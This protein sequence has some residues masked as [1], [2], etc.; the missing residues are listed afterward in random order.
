MTTT[1]PPDGKEIAFVRKD[2]TGGATS[3]PT[4][5]CSSLPLTVGPAAEVLRESRLLKRAGGNSP[6]GRLI[7]FRA[8]MRAGFEADRW[9]LLVFD[10]AT[11]AVRN[12]TEPFD[13]QVG[14]HR[15]VGPI[16]G[17]SSSRAEDDA[18]DSH[19]RGA[20][21]PAAPSAPWPAA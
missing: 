5:S 15:V 19:L 6:D 7:A 1:S 16:R 17:R 12:L 8:Q 20:E 9:R 4:A 21:P 13:R 18:R 2:A 11:R 14:R 10:R 3:E